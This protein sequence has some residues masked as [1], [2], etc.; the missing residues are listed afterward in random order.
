MTQQQMAANHVQKKNPANF[1]SSTRHAVAT[2]IKH[3]MNL[4]LVRTT[5]L[6]TLLTSKHTHT[7]KQICFL[8]TCQTLFSKRPFP[9]HV[10]YLFSHSVLCIL[11]CLLFNVCCVLFHFFYAIVKFCVVFVEEIFLKAIPVKY[12]RI[13]TEITKYIPPLQTK[14]MR[15]DENA[16]IQAVFKFFSC[17]TSCY[18]KWTSL[19]YYSSNRKMKNSV[20][21]VPRNTNNHVQDLNSGRR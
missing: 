4:M 21:S 6:Q 18:T 16:L 5:Y 15:G 11:N 19:F 7:G 2:I 8:L 9:H 20:I 13:S 10:F 1:L 14:L 17:L 12:R 3:G